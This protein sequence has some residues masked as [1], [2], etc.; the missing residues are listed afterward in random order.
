[1][2]PFAAKVCLQGGGNGCRLVRTV[3]HLERDDEIWKQPAGLLATTSTTGEQRRHSGPPTPLSLTTASVAKATL[4]ADDAQAQNAS[5]RSSFVEPLVDG[6]RRQEKF[7]WMST[8]D[9]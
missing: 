7:Q 6:G 8:S 5:F 4:L 1:M 2:L 9:S 3:L